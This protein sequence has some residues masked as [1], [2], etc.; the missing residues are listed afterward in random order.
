MRR[1]TVKFQG[2]CTRCGAELTPGD[3]AMYEK[4]TGIFCPGCEPTEA[5]DIR[6]FRLAKAEKKA[7][8]YDEWAGKREKKSEAALNSFPGIRHDWAFIT[9]PGR[10]PFRDRMNR[11]DDRAMESLKKAGEMRRKAETLRT[12]RVAGDRE[13]KR[14]AQRELADTLIK[15]GSMVHDACFGK[16][17]VVGV[18]KKSYRIRFSSG[19]TCARDKSY[20]CPI[21]GV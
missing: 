6:T 7:A 21:E 3:V 17:E 13:R 4:T 16:G 18:F 12:V 8:R 10:I 1:L 20:V 15:K 19:F 5:E 14:E 11:A 2:Y 9:Q